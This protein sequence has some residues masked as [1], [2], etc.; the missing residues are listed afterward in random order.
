MDVNAQAGPLLNTNIM[1]IRCLQFWSASCLCYGKEC[2][3]HPRQISNNKGL[4][5][6]LA[7]YQGECCH[8]DQ[9]ILHFVHSFRATICGICP[10]KLRGRTAVCRI[11]VGVRVESLLDVT[12]MEL[13]F[14]E[15]ENKYYRTSKKKKWLIN[16]LCYKNRHITDL[17]GLA[18]GVMSREHV[19]TGLMFH[20]QGPLTAGRCEVILC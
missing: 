18:G 9:W 20:K 2:T 7:S 5:C 11:T 16:S 12:Q 1:K 15:W 6:I 19:M 3:T 13:H 17:A 14:N 10:W 4:L 8:N